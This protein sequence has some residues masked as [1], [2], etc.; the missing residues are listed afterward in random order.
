VLARNKAGAALFQMLIIVLCS[1][2]FAIYR[3]AIQRAM[4]GLF[5]GIQG[6]SAR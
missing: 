3:E 4:I 5:Q 1:L 6:V 2:A